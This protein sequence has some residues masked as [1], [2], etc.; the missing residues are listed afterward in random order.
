MLRKFEMELLREV[1]QP[2]TKEEGV[3]GSR[4]D[5]CSTSDEIK[6]KVLGLVY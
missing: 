1:D 5:D 3:D 2:I 6:K 4:R